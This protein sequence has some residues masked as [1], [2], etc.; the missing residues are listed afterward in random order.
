MMNSTGGIW[1]NQGVNLPEA[2][3]LH[4]IAETSQEAINIQSR[5]AILEFG[6]GEKKTNFADYK[7]YYNSLGADFESLAR[8]QSLIA[9][10]DT[11]INTL[12]CFRSVSRAIPEMVTISAP[13][14][15]GEAPLTH[16]STSTFTGNQHT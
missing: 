1:R 6:A 2:A 15:L 10:G 16:F 5:P 11:Q 4:E 3:F 9:E 7:A 13:P 12:Y 8:L 14:H